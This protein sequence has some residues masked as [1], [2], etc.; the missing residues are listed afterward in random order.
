MAITFTASTSEPRSFSLGPVKIQV[1]TYRALSGTTSGT[2]TA[3]QLQTT[4]HIFLSNQ[5]KF[6]AAPTHSGNVSTLAFVVPTETAA[7]L[8]VQDLTYT[9]VAD[10][11]QDGNSITIAYTGSGT[12]GAE[13]VTVTGT[14]ISIQIGS[15]VSTATQIRTAFNA[16]AAAVALASCAVSGTGS[17]AQT[18]ASAT[19]LAGGVTG[20]ARGTC[21]LIGT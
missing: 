12:A 3:D 9:A 7:S 10:L 19:P 11:G 1:G 13:V 21:L 4:K 8:I 15:G 5:I 2:I 6:T 20:G 17:N 14:A 16:S 18:T